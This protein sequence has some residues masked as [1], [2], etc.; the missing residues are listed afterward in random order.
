MQGG[1]FDPREPAALKSIQPCLALGLGRAH[2]PP[3]V[4]FQNH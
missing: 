1:N 2:P 3:E 4:R